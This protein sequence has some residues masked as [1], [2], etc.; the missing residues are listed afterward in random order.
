MGKAGTPLSF[1]SVN[2][3]QFFGGKINMW[4]EIFKTGTQTDSAG[5]S[6]EF[7]V[8]NLE[9]IA[10]MYNERIAADESG[11]AP[12]VKG[13][14][15]DNEPAYGWVERLGRRGKKLLAKLKELDT[16]F[17]QEVKNGAFRKIS[18]AIYPLRHWI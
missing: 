5:N 3:V 17:L 6:R 12:V 15:K 9:E 13:H 10:A 18:M 8:E 4:I 7:T 11:I 14:P 2:F 16:D 1:A